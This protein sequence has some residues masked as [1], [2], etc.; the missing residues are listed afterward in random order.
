MLPMF[1]PN[2]ANLS[3]VAVDRAGQVSCVCVN[4]MSCWS[5][6]IYFTSCERESSWTLTVAKPLT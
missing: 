6:V 2:A 5:S 1:L 4:V 3:M